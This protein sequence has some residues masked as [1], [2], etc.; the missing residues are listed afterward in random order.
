MAK[1]KSYVVQYRRKREGKTDYKKRL[2]LLKSG[3]TRLVV[4]PSNKHMFV[5][6]VDYTE[7][8]DRVVSCASSKELSGFGWTH[9][10]SNTPAAYLT[11]LLCGVKGKGKKVSEAVLDNGLLTAIKG[12]RLFAALKGCLDA[13]V[14]IPVGTEILPDESRIQG[15]HIASHV[16]R[17]KSIASDFTKVKEAI[18]KSK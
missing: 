16:E 8:G 9:S 17:S 6:L 3:K 1:N 12:S 11:G 13:G 7:E 15:Q 18:L 5:Q 4:R 2:N 10:T 14:V